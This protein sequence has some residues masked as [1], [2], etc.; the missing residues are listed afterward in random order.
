MVADE[1]PHS[2][3]TCPRRWSRCEPTVPR[4]RAGVVKLEPLPPSVARARL[5]E[6]GGAYEGDP[7]E[8]FPTLLPRCAAQTHSEKELVAN[9][10]HKKTLLLKHVCELSGRPLKSNYNWFREKARERPTFASP[11]ATL[12][13]LTKN[14]RVPPPSRGK[15]YYNSI[16]NGRPSNPANI[17]SK[18][19][20]KIIVS[21]R[22][23]FGTNSF[24]ELIWAARRGGS[25]REF[26]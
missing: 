12:Q 14:L 9:R 5:E 8:N 22:H 15:T 26:T 6:T 24:P 7:Y 1:T 2:P 20:H 17:F 18:R 3:R 13:V 19:P 11:P 21:S 10:K 23:L 25:A 4:A 16:S